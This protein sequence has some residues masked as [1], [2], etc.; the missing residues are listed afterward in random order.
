MGEMIDIDAT[1]GVNYSCSDIEI[2]ETDGAD[3]GI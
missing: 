3:D 2:D 1:R